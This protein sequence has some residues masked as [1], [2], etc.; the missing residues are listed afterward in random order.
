VNPIIL[1]GESDWE[2]RPPQRSWIF[3]VDVPDLSGFRSSLPVSFDRLETSD[4]EVDLAVGLLECTVG[5]APFGGGG[6]VRSLW[7]LSGQL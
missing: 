6:G 2:F 3:S 4:D 1:P 7:L 5:V